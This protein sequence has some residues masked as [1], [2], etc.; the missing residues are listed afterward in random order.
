M[1][2]GK[3]LEPVHELALEAER[4]AARRLA[5]T[6]HEAV[7]SRARLE[8]LEVYEREYRV[9]LQQRVLDGIAAAGLRDYQAF[10]ARLG[11]AVTQQRAVCERV[12]AGRDAA[13][14]QW[15]ALTA[16]R[17]AV[18]KIIEQAVDADR[19]VRERREQRELDEHALRSFQGL[20]SDDEVG[21]G[22]G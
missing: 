9:A 3:R 20:A 22:P 6:E 11:E 15:L 4:A 2:R 18:G 16:R 7:E 10:L 13:R 14:E 17:R 21:R 12:A 8:Q 1:K 5:D 19:R